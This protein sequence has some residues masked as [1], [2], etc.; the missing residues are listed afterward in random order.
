MIRTVRYSAGGGVQVS[1]EPGAALFPRQA[2]DGEQSRTVAREPGEVVWIDFEGPTDEEFGL[3]AK[4]FGFHPLAIEDCAA[5]THHPK[6]DEYQGYVFAVMHGV[7]LGANREKFATTELDIFL[8]PTFLVTFHRE[9]MAYVDETREAI[10][11]SPR[12]MSEGSDFLLYEILT[13]LG[14]NYLEVIEEFSK[15]IEDVEDEVFAGAPT[16]TLEKL[17]GLKREVLHLKRV[18]AP[19]REVIRRLSQEATVVDEKAKAYYSD[20]YD[21]FY[22]ISETAD[23]YRDLLTGLLDA[24][25]AV[26]SNRIN[27]VMKVLTIIAT[28]MMP[29]TVIVGLYG[30]NFR[31]MPEL[32]WKYGYAMVWGVMVTTAGSLLYYFKRRGWL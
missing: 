29:L 30:M 11:K 31:Y 19:Q 14:E 28:I 20:V 4:N 32:G 16:R 22:R 10:M 2:R 5:E 21:K 7:N 12:M 23:V 26:V 17:T 1:S 9:K 3:L 24:C 25:L 13:R 27:E 15:E 18:V 8:G 6:M